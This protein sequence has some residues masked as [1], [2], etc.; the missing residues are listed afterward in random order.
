MSFK[1]KNRRLFCRP[2]EPSGT[3]R[4]AGGGLA[5][6]C[7]CSLVSTLCFAWSGFHM[8]ADEFPEM[9]GGGRIPLEDI[10]AVLAVTVLLFALPGRRF[11]PCRRVF[12]GL[13]PFLGALAARRIW[14]EYGKEILS[15]SYQAAGIVIA[16]VNRHY[17]FNFSLPEG[18][19][20]YCLLAVLCIGG[21]LL[22]SLLYAAYVFRR[23][24]IVMGFPLLALGLGLLAGRAPGLLGV[25]EC[26]TGLLFCRAGGWE[27]ARAARGSAEKNSR[28]IGLRAGRGLSLAVLVLLAALLPLG[29]SA[30]FSGAAKELAENGGGVVAIQRKMEE[31]L[32][33]NIQRLSFTS[34][35]AVKEN[36]NNRTPKYREQEILRVTLAEKP[37]RTLY[38]RGFY[39]GEYAGGGWNSN[40]DVLQEALAGQEWTE[41]DV[42]RWLVG[43]AG[44]AEEDAGE[45]AD[46]PSDCTLQFLWRSG[47]VYTPYFLVPEDPGGGLRYGGEYQIK[48]KR[49]MD[50]VR[51]GRG[52]REQ[53]GRKDGMAE[54]YGAYVRENYHTGSGDVPSAG[55]IAKELLDAYAGSYGIALETWP[56]ES[57]SFDFRQSILTEDLGSGDP[58][59]RN[60]ARLH[61]AHAVS[62][63]LGSGV[64][65]QELDQVPDGTD[66]VEYFLSESKTGYC[67][68]YASAGVLILQAM[69]IPA[70][71]AS[72]YVAPAS[73]FRG[74]AGRYVL[75]LKDSAAHAWAEIYLEDIGW[76]PVEMTP[77]YGDG[78][79]DR[80]EAEMMEIR[81]D[82]TLRRA[83]WMEDETEGDASKLPEASGEPDTPTGEE[84][85]GD[86]ASPEQAAESAGQRET[87]SAESSGA[88]PA[89]GTAPSG[90]VGGSISA[91]NA[92]I[93]ETIW[94]VLFAAVCLAGMAAA[95][96]LLLRLSAAKKRRKLRALLGDI[97]QRRNR[98]AVLRMNRSV[99]RRMRVKNRQWFAR[100]SDEEYRQMLIR[101][102][103][104]TA[105]EEWEE[106]I[107]IAR[108]ASFSR[109]E[110]SDAE[111]QAV[112][113][114]F[115]AL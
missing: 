74:E 5:A 23:R 18:Q 60:Q 19:A 43:R 111:V 51:F 56:F 25:A 82:L 85:A 30:R 42:A 102:F 31:A 59:I 34:E 45:W 80:Q 92:K 65:S 16:A 41:E 12:L 110:I 72:G 97:R 54:W 39:G 29:I 103:P 87:N 93:S 6:D 98:Q 95:L 4:T 94:P 66:V 58:G 61:F 53:A 78:E 47:A 14:T 44:T 114:I 49:S 13:A 33:L 71:Y 27:S 48:K 2:K 79:T 77:G 86:T 75:S 88:G 20:G 63:Y 99:Y 73:D 106:F 105:K 107:G 8:L 28:R 55:R 115:R 1:E 67:V 113:G 24:W 46:F 10:S 3:G 83:P 70:R 38:F 96:I 89:G 81:P 76:V 112:Y 109:S 11:L 26:F 84:T 7:F 101:T 36:I 68:H 22:L 62:A 91:G 64:Y 40:P 104:D 35:D 90:N 21:F 57:E 32:E 15:G 17:K 9:Y 37:E 69:G 52:T 50:T 108:K 100:V